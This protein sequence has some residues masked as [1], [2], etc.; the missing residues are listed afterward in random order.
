MADQ[1]DQTTPTEVTISSPGVTV[2]LKAHAPLPEVTDRAEQ[3]H[4]R[5]VRRH[6]DATR[7]PEGH[8]GHL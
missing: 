6:A 5:A 2:T 4:E 1:P 3:I 7:L 8:G